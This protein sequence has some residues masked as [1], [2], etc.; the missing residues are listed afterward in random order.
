MFHAQLA[1]TRG[2]LSAV[3]TKHVI[4]FPDP[5]RAL[6]YV[7]VHINAAHYTCLLI[8]HGKDR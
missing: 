1:F 7:R 6:H 8:P 4:L 5:M 2:T 3:L